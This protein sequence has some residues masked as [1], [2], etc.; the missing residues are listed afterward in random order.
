MNNLVFNEQLHQYKLDGIVIPGVTE[1]LTTA[2]LINFDFVS[3][4]VL[5]YSADLGKK[6][7]STTELYDRQDLD[8]TTL[9]PTLISY[10]ESW[11]KFK[12]AY[13]FIPYGIETQYFHPVYKF[14]GRLDRVGYIDAGGYMALVDIKSGVKA[15]HHEI[16]TAGYKILYDYGK[17]R[18]EQIKRRFCV[19]L[20]ED[21]YKVEEHK[22]N[23]D[24]NVF[25]SCL[26]IT[27][28]K[29]S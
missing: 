2:G 13:N 19:Y 4:D 10:L 26:S 12:K 17:K 6:V 27:N 15:K 7:H 9:H 23:N 11:I 18:A 20:S 28:Y 14:A 8:V 22:N 5:E 25:L 21:D 24:M 16:Q 1:I 3:P 29:R